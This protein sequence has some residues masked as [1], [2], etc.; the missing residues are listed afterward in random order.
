MPIYDLVCVSPSSKF[1][2]IITPLPWLIVLHV[3]FRPAVR[4][5]QPPLLPFVDAHDIQSS[6]QIL[7]SAPQCPTKLPGKSF[8]IIK[9]FSCSCSNNTS[10]DG[11]LPLSPPLVSMSP[12]TGRRGA[13]G[14]VATATSARTQVRTHVRQVDATVDCYVTLILAQSVK[15]CPGE[16][17]LTSKFCRLRLCALGHIGRPSGYSRGV[18]ASRGRQQRLL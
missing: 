7:T 9:P 16:K 12:T 15:L 2:F 13:S 14:V 11:K 1:S 17:M 6:L 18:Y 5:S 8:S 10:V 3:Y 4:S